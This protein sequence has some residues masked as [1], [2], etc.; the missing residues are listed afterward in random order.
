MR[1][2]ARIWCW[3]MNE[4]IEIYYRLVGGK[5]FANIFPLADTLLDSNML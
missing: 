1:E 2:G 5:H 3:E 4:S